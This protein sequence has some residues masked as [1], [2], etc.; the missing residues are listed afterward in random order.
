M[1]QKETIK[2]L[3]QQLE[4]LRITTRKIERAITSSEGEQKQDQHQQVAAPLEAETGVPRDTDGWIIRI[5]DRVCFLN[6]EKFL[7]RTGVIVRFS[8][9][10]T[11]VISRDDNNQE[12]IWAPRNVQ[13]I[14]WQASCQIQ[15][16]LVQPSTGPQMKEF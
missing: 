8:T 9:N 5:G 4:S 11:W 1:N 15:E 2:D 16:L 10:H 7:T 3:R 14:N 12:L 13:I 6:K